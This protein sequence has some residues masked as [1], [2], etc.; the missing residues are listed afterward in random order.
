MDDTQSGSRWS[1]DEYEDT[2]FSQSPPMTSQTNTFLHRDF[3]R[4]P[5]VRL[6]AGVGS[7]ELPVGCKLRSVRP[8]ID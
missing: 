6:E 3:P 5:L 4:R 2:A 7:N 8:W 1:R